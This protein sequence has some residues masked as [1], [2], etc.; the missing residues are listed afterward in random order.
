[1]TVYVA[2]IVTSF[3]MGG[4][5]NGIVNIVNASDPSRV[6]HT[7]LSMR[8]KLDLGERLRQGSVRTVGIPEGR[9]PAA[10]RLIADELARI[11]PDVVHTRNWGTYP[12]GILAARRAGVRGPERQ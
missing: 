1:M 10:Y 7:V 8:D 2:H 12:D 4:L 9:V 11:G 3:D 5:H 6:R